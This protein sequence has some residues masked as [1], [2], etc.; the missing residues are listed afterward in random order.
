MTAVIVARIHWHALKLWLKRL[1]IV[2]RPAPPQRPVTRAGDV[3]SAVPAR[4][5]AGKT[6]ISPTSDDPASIQNPA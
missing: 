6:R 1:G 2:A 4:R 3:A 5:A